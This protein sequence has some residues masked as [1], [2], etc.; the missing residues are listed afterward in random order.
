MSPTL[1]ERGAPVSRRVQRF[2]RGSG[3]LYAAQARSLIPPDAFSADSRDM[4]LEPA[5]FGIVGR[6]GR[7][8]QYEANVAALVGLLEAKWAAK[9]RRLIAL[10]SASLD[11]GY[12]TPLVL[13]TNEAADKRHGQLW[14]RSSNAGLTQAQANHTWGEEFSSTTYPQGADTTLPVFKMVP[15]PYIS[16]GGTGASPATGLT[17]CTNELL[18]RFTAPG[19]REVS[20]YGSRVI[21]TG[22]QGCPLEWNGEWNDTTTSVSKTLRAQPAGLWPP[23]FLPTL[24]T[25]V[26]STTE[27]D[28]NWRNG[29][30]FYRSVAFRRRDGAW[31]R[32]FQIRPVDAVVNDERGGLW[33]IGDST[34]VGY[35]RSITWADIPQPGDDYDEIALLRTHKVNINSA[36]SVPDYFATGVLADIPQTLYIVKILK[37][38]V[39][40]YVDSF[41]SDES[42]GNADLILNRSPEGAYTGILPPCARYSIDID[43]RRVLLYTRPNPCAIVLAPTGVTAS[44]DLNLPDD[45]ALPA[46]ATTMF[47]VRVVSGTSSATEPDVELVRYTA[48]GATIGTTTIAFGA[49]KT[50]QD[51]VDEINATIVGSG[52]GEWGAQ[53]APGVDGALLMSVL[54]PTTHQVANCTCTGTTLT[55]TASAPLHRFEQVAIGMYVTDGTATV[56]VT[57]KL[58]DLSLTLSGTITAANITVR[59]LTDTGDNTS[60]VAAGG[61]IRAHSPNLFAVLPMA[62]AFLE[63]FPAGSGMTNAW[64]KVTGGYSKVDP[65]ALWITGLAKGA[66]TI[67]PLLFINDGVH[68]RGP[69]ATAGIGM[70]GGPLH[71]GG[72]ICYSR[73][74]YTF[75][76]RREGNSGD[77]ADYRLYVLNA[78][79]GCVSPY[80][81]HGDGWVGYWTR[82]GFIVTDGR[83]EV[84]LTGRLHDPGSVTGTDGHASRS[85]LSY[86]LEQAGSNT[87]SDGSDYGLHAWIDGFALFISF[88]V[89]ANTRRSLKYDFSEGSEASGLAEVLDRNGQP[90]PWSAQLT[91]PIVCGATIGSNSATSPPRHMAMIDTNAGSTGDGQIQLIGSTYAD[92]GVA[93][94]PIAYLMTDFVGELRRQKSIYRA[95]AFYRAQVAGMEVLLSIDKDRA[96]QQAIAL[97]VNTENDP[98]E[99][100]VPRELRKYGPCIEPAVR[101]TGGG[102]RGEFFGLEVEVE[103]ATV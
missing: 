102:I 46:P 45:A 32:P 53:L 38:G 62:G 73:A 43:Q 77:D 88:R 82:E 1:L 52:G 85:I 72:V 98:R 59:F 42:L 20:T 56:Q 16:K 83:N 14:F 95:T 41:G 81:V 80:I 5:S 57:D 86:E 50:L 70:G 31:T 40:S 33:V 35:K 51:V 47:V 101:D 36:A 68:R 75:E 15:L 89:D 3:G 29:D 92:D 100:D 21:T 65:R 66:S 6:L 11:D 22:F 25:E 9:P 23:L 8:T 93:F 49:T 60:F 12:P 28:R 87:D 58:S 76:N 61:G 84:L 94:T 13:F 10:Q 26:A 7:V 103:V 19:S 17:R 69:P 4:V 2:Y 79:R 55:T 24:G 71:L 78:K 99:L 90:R 74:I 48:G 64:P 27:Q 34:T 18:R 67:A 63:G 96:T 54:A 44:R 91:M 30:A 97:E 37:K 39:T